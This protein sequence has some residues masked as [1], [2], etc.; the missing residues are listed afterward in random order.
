MIFDPSK[1]FL[2]TTAIDYTNDTIHIGHA[3]EKVLADA[4]AR[5]LK[6][7][8]GDN[9]VFFVTGTDEHGTTNEKAAAKK[10]VPVTQHVTEIS[11]GNKE[12]YKHLNLDYD[13][14]IRTTDQD[15]INNASNFFKKS[16]DNGFIYKGKY[17]GLYCEGCESYKT[18]SELVDGKCSLHPTR[19]IQ[20]Y[21]EDNYF[22]KWSHFNEFLKDLLINDKLVIYPKSRKIEMLSLL[23]KGLEDIPVTR[24][25]FKLSWGITCPVD[26]TQV[27]YV[28][29][30]A[31]IN[32]HTAGKPLGYWQEDTEIIHFV[33]K[34]IARWHTLLW[35]AMLKSVDEKLPNYVNIHAFMNLN[36]QKISKSTG[37]LIRPDDITQ[38]IDS[39]ALRWYLLKFGPAS[40]DVDISINHIKEVYNADLANGLGNAVA[41]V[42]K[43]AER[44]GFE[45]PADS[46]RLSTEELDIY[47]PL[48]E[49]RMDNVVNNISTYISLLDQEI[50]KDTP[51]AEKDEIKLKTKLTKY[52]E[53]IRKIAY[54]ITPLMPNT[55]DKINRQFG[56]NKVVSTEG[57]F[58]RII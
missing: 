42:A 45:F 25:K 14:F 44:S 53:W 31:L 32:Y 13:R 49:F 16:F 52:V 58:P 50:N 37:N 46:L 5:F 8:M 55:A 21:Q 11:N 15:H 10:N 7:R 38:I 19:E 9:K 41:R 48:E 24:P 47:K 20:K 6:Q 12:Q 28:W 2:I 33:G 43:L 36:G 30:D 56:S 51:W 23:E 34:D 54:L 1:K 17:E 57:I 35:P 3:Y 18:L 22:F 40:E 29:F 39:D 4:W 26:E 27:L